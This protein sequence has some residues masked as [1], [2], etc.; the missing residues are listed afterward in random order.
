MR[1][2]YRLVDATLCDDVR[3]EMSGKLVLIGVYLR[4][5]IV[6][7]LP[8]ILPSFSVLLKWRAG[9]GGVPAGVIRI[10]RPDDSVASSMSVE[11][12]PPTPPGGR[13]LTVL[14][15]Q[16]FGF[17]L[18]GRYRI[19]F[20]PTGGRQRSLMS[21]EVILQQLPSGQ[22]QPR[23]QAKSPGATPPSSRPLASPKRRSRRR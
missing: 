7:Q 17:T 15:F 1:P 19:V 22:A 20:A 23:P 9:P 3:Q 11:A 2:S 10:L 12:C 16:P 13:F 18:A 14:K 5:V 21:F 6:F 4:N 8:T